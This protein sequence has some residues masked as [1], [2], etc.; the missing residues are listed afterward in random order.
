M[1]EETS[2]RVSD[3]IKPDSVIA[4]LRVPDKQRALRELARFAAARID[5]AENVVHEAL[6]ARERLG[7]TGVGVGVAVPHARIAGLTGVHGVFARLARPIEFDAIDGRPVDLV[8]LLL[9]PES[10]ASEHLAALACASRA[11]R[12]PATAQTLRGTTDGAAL[13]AILA[14]QSAS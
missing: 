2:V 7:S 4:D 13:Y 8:F 3:L 10:A 1:R 6:L 14:D 9:V 12:N 5:V 11:L